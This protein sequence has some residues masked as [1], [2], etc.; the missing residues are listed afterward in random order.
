MHLGRQ[1]PFWCGWKGLGQLRHRKSEKILN[2]LKTTS[3]TGSRTTQGSSRAISHDASPH[4]SPTPLQLPI[5]HKTLSQTGITPS[6]PS[7]SPKSWPHYPSTQMRSLQL[8]GASDL[9]RLT[10]ATGQSVPGP[11]VPCSTQVPPSHPLRMQGRT[12][13]ETAKDFSKE[14]GVPDV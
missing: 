12:R 9:L 10:A 3:P 11:C 14:E 13:P 4:S 1:R 8:R 5:G 7:S 2:R 6:H